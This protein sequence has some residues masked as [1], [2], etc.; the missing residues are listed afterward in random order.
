[1]RFHFSALA[2]LLLLSPVATEAYTQLDETS[3][4]W[5]E[6]VAPFRIAGNIYY[7]GAAEVSAFL[8]TTPKGHILLDGGFAETAPLVRDSIRQLGFQLEEVK[9][10]LTSHSHY[11]HVGGLAQLK[12]WTGAQL[13]AHTADA[14]QLE[15][16]GK[17]DRQW[18]DKFSFAPV[19]VDRRLKDGDT[20]TLGGVTLTARWTPGHTPGC[21]SWTMRVDDG[22]PLDVVFV[23]STSAPEYKLVGNPSYPDIVEDYER[24][25]RVL[26][27]LPC[28]VFLAAHGSFF[29]L[30]EKAEKLRQ[31]G[32]AKAGNP[33]VDP[34]GYRDYLQ[35][36]EAD[37][38]KRLAEQRR[39]AAKPKG[40]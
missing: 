33:F 39:S 19:K 11:D 40:R 29:H 8:I 5:N 9:F 20:V 34:Q 37:F 13:L 3:R 15:S 10:L 17:G 18:G 30:K 28:D 32:A 12:A 36:S 16:G 21:T 35:R 6:P 26:K 1:M 27:A 22:A 24:T 4:A 25:F 7:V 38:R 2:L 23:G 14:E 31:P